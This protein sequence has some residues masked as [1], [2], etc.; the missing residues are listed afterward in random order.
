VTGCEIL[1]F[2]TLASGS[3]GNSTLVSH[4]GAN[5]LIDAGIS[6]RRIT[7]SLRE[8]G[9]MPSDLSAI[10]I[11]HEHSDHV[12]GLAT[13]TR[14]YHTPVYAPRETAAALLASIPNLYGVLN[15]FEADSVFNIRD[16]L[17]HSFRTPHDTPDS[18]GFKVTAGSRSF[19]VVTDLGFVPDSVFNAVC[20]SDAVILE[21]NHDIEMLK[22]GSYPAFLKKRILGDRGHLSN[23]ACGEVSRRLI[24]SGTRQIVLAHLSKEN[25]L[26]QLA[27]STVDN[28]IRSGA[29]APDDFR[30]TVAPRDIAG[31]RYTL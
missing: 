18:V 27:Y 3:S 19:S 14:Y 28:L 20:G 24:E 26:P 29:D 23:E 21:A 8:L 4:A 12:N 31:R 15:G 9:L 22:Y 5:I 11:T 6:M 1:E 30:L 7:S 10:L 16:M 17:I 25:N 2:C 13:L